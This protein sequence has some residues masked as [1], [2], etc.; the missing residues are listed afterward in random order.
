MLRR[1]LLACGLALGLG[2]LPASSLPKPTQRVGEPRPSLAR[3][4]EATRSS[5]RA[6][7]RITRLS[8][9]EFWRLA[10]ESSEP[11]G[12]FRSDN[13][14]SNEIMFQRVIPELLERTGGGGVY[15]GVGPEQN[16]TYMA[17]LQPE[18]AII[19]DIRRGNLLLQL[20]YKAIF[21]LTRNRVEF[22]SMLFSKP[23]PR[24]LAVQST[25]AGLFAAFQ[26]V[27]GDETSYLRNLHAIRERLTLVHG[28]PLSAR[29]VEGI[30]YVYH[31]FY[32]RGFEIRYSPS[33]AELMTQ[34]D[35]AGLPRSYLADEANFAFLKDLET[36]NLVV[37]V[38]GDF[39]GPKAIRA[40]GAYL[41]AHD[42][43]VKAFYLSNVE[44]YLF[45]ENK[46]AA[47]CRNVA[48]L[49]LDLSSTFIRATRGA[50]AGFGVGFVTSLGAISAEIRECS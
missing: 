31:A 17:A 27:P 6:A 47:F 30:E 37:P 39:A 12:Y 14:T 25:A 5:N 32:S 15:L 36:K 29:D 7:A 21:E 43:T 4:G 24:E 1:L 33:Y 11:D 49:P 10:T 8:D 22:V 35:N 45:Q 3:F 42:R 16:F 18:I 50:G 19:F 41:K 13:L 34:T 40:V 44:Q 2:L 46:W 26:R 20:M 9:Q 23:R 38:V 48:T 28:L